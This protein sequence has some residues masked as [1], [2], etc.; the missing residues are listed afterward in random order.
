MMIN[1]ADETC[2]G[3]NPTVSSLISKIEI[4]GGYPYIYKMEPS[5]SLWIV[6]R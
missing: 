6:D 1:P 2:A 5:N 3:E 4:V